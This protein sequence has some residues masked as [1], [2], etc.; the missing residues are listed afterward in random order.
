MEQFDHE[1]LAN[2][3]ET[4]SF[5][6]NDATIKMWS[7]YLNGI[8]IWNKAYNL[9]SITEREE[10]LVKHLFD[11]IVLIPYLEKKM[12]HRIIDIG[13]GAGLPGFLLAIAM[14]DIQFVLLDSNRKRI[15]FMQ[16]MKLEL[17]V[18]N[19]E[20]VHSRV[21]DYHPAEPFDLVLSRA[22]ASG[23][24]MVSWSNHLLSENGSF[25]A[26]KGHVNESEWTASNQSFQ[27]EIIPLSV[28]LLNEA[29]HLIFLS[30]I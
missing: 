4:S 30:P 12:P 6:F 7:H 2:A 16:Q 19:V 29:R 27:S 11:S 14:K 15:R 13:T 18:K 5:S 20:I 10:M 23:D 17:G 3:L 28:P 1:Y 24:D 9:T 21:Q 25:A 22:F 26:M 8:Q